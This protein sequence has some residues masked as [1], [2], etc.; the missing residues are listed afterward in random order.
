MNDAVVERQISAAELLSTLPAV[1][2]EIVEGQ[3]VFVVNL[4]QAHEHGLVIGSLV[5]PQDEIVF[6]FGPPEVLGQVFG[7]IDE[8]YGWPREIQISD[9]RSV[10]DLTPSHRCHPIICRGRECLAMSIGWGEYEL[11]KR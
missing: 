4:G 8:E 1:I 5:S 7:L 11:L 2:Q 10:E 6:V 3:T 9:I